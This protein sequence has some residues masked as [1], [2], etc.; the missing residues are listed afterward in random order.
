V[1]GR[2]M[3][4]V[5]DVW[6]KGNTT[7]VLLM[8]VKGAFPHVAKVNIIKTMEEMGLEADLVRWVGSV[9]EDRRVIM[10]MD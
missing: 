10:S 2:V 9:V 3:K 4:R 6:G 5:E 1:A 8:D 7:A